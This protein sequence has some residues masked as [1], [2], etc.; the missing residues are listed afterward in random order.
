M[1]ASASVESIEAILG[2]GMFEIPM[3]QRPYSWGKDEIETFCNDI[4]GLDNHEHHLLGM[5]VLS[6]MEE[7]KGGS[8]VYNI[9]DGQQRIT[10]CLLALSICHDLLTDWSILDEVQ[11]KRSL[12][13]RLDEILSDL[14]GKLYD[15]R[16]N[17]PKLITKNENEIERI[18]LQCLLSPPTNLDRSAFEKVNSELDNYDS[19]PSDQK[20]T[21]KLKKRILKQWDQR[22]V[23]SKRAIKN[24]DT[25]EQFIL[26]CM[27][28]MD[29]EGK[30]CFIDEFTTKILRSLQC[31]QFIVD[32]EY[33]A[34]KLFE[35][36]NDRGLGISAMDLV[37]NLGLRYVHA[38]NCNNDEGAQQFFLSKWK[39]IFE[40]NLPK[41][42]LLFLRYANN[43][44]RPFKKASEIYQ[45]YR[46]DVFTSVEAV[47]GE[48]SSLEGLSELFR[49]CYD[50]DRRRASDP[51]QIELGLLQST[52]TSQWIV[53]A[54]ALLHLKKQVGSDHDKKIKTILRLVYELVFIQ[55]VRELGAN[56]FE[57]QFPKWALEI[58]RSIS[59]KDRIDSV[60]NE[61]ISKCQLKRRDL[62]ELK[63]SELTSKRFAKNDVAKAACYSLHLI[64]GGRHGHDISLTLQLEHIY[65]QSPAEDS[66]TDFSALDE[67]RRHKLTYSLGNFILLDQLLNPSVGNSDFEIKKKGYKDHKVV[68]QLYPMGGSQNAVTELSK[69]T[70]ESIETRSQKMADLI[71]QSLQDFCRAGED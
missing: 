43:A 7:K 25:I 54:L 41:G 18:V 14:K 56:Q 53:I 61:V 39:Q 15:R 40:N 4:H 30:V 5:I 68:D 20:S 50:S 24:H 31:V 10:T 11:S 62:G 49:D 28:K 8:T 47:K 29:A 46:D 63:P 36:M 67:E 65:P 70:P 44:R 66:W 22:S 9:I 45:V 34:F 6:P 35:T 48:M 42:H 23:K 12:K 69:F 1:A 59:D 52:N 33:N 64:K 26:T 55:I 27:E 32:T 3:Y 60:L 17:R 38:S 21:T 2:R 58:Y 13:D 71:I 51:F 37:K 57:K 16:A 19:L